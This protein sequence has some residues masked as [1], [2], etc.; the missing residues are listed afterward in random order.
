MQ[1]AWH[2]LQEENEL[3]ISEYKIQIRLAELMKI[4]GVIYTQLGSYSQSYQKYQSA[5]YYF[6]AIH[7]ED[8]QVLIQIYQSIAS[9]CIKLGYWKT[10]ID[11][12][13]K[14]QNLLKGKKRAIDK[15]QVVQ[16]QITTQLI[17][18]EI[19]LEY[20]TL[21][22]AKSIYDKLEAGLKKYAFTLF[23]GSD[24]QFYGIKLLQ[25]QSIYCQKIFSI[26]SAEKKLRR[27]IS[28][29]RKCAPNNH[30]LHTELQ[31]QL[32][33]IALQNNDREQVTLMLKKLDTYFTRN[34]KNQKNK[35]LYARFQLLKGKILCLL[36]DYGQSL[37][38]LQ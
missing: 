30:D 5:L 28:S 31:C 25:L 37:A 26:Q 29:A 6:T 33:E 7:F 15:A 2:E 21:F 20:L 3:H 23:K 1:R 11:Y 35:Y 38:A 27:A 10:A 8:P 34:S 36:E 32:L 19:S 14:M 12:Y 17:L 9:C 24:I 22:N 13:F 4:M 18:F 16:F